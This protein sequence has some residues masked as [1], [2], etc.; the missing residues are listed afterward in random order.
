LHRQV[1][2]IFTLEDAI[3]VIG[4][5]EMGGYGS[6]RSG[7]EPTVESEFAF[8]ID[9]DALRRDGLIRLGARAGCV[10]RFS[11][12]CRDLKVECETHIGSP[13]NDWVRLKYEMRDYWTDELL[14]IDDKVYLVPTH[15]H[16]GGLRW[17]FVCPHLNRRVRTL[18]LPRSGRHFW[19]R[20]AYELAYACQ[21]ETN[22]DR[23]LRRARKLR[24][25]LGGDP[26][27]DEYPDKPPRMRWATYNR[28]MVKLVAA[29]DVANER[30]TSLA[31]R[32]AGR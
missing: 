6:G 3:D 26:A 30:L 4:V 23:A 2:R 12:P 24:L 17:W 1:S 14:K 29:D 15:P 20:H 7:G 10:I 31:A 28:L 19:S 5:C 8:R 22:F 32:W 21:R 25:R 13:W 27:D 18:Y 11:H 9:I 16:F